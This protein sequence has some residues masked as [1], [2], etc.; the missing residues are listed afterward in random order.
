M[1]ENLPALLHYDAACCALA[2]AVRVDEVKDI[3][4]AAVAMR[5][6]AKQ[7]KNRES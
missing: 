1:S 3:L 5:A 2:E 6:Y 7:A 4:D